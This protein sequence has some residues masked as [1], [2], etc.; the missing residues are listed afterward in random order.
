MNE[1][2]TEFPG[3]ANVFED[4]AEAEVIAP[5]PHR[6]QFLA[7]ST[8][9]IAAGVAGCRRPDLEILPFAEN[10]DRA[11]P[12]VPLY[13]ATAMPRS[14]GAAPLLVECND[15]RPTKIEGHPT[16][17]ASMGGTDAFAQAAILDLYSPDRSKQVLR[18]R[19]GQLVASSWTAFDAFAVEHFGALRKTGG[20]G[21]RFLSGKGLS[22]ATQLLREGVKARFPNSIWHEHEPIDDAS[23]QKGFRLAFGDLGPPMRAIPRFDAAKRILAL[24]S[25]FLGLE[26]P[27]AGFSRAFAN[28]RRD[29]ALQALV[30][31]QSLAEK[32]TAP[33]DAVNRLYVVESAYSST[34]TL[35]DHRLR[36][37]SSKIP[38]YLLALASL[39]AQRLG[40]GVDLRRGLNS[41]SPDGVPAAWIQEVAADLLASRGQCLILA[42]YRQPPIVHAVCAWLNQAL[43]NVGK[44]INYFFLPDDNARPLAELAIALNDGK[45]QTLVVLGGNPVFSAPA[46]LNF[47]QALSKAATVVSLGAFVDETSE[48]STWHLPEA[49]FLEMWDDAVSA[50]GRYC[51]VQP[52]IAPLHQGRSSLEALIHLSAHDNASTFVE[53]KSKVFPLLRASFEKRVESGDDLAFKAFIQRGHATQAKPPAPVALSEQPLVRALSE[54]RPFAIPPNRLEVTFC[55]SS[56]V[57]DGRYAWN[58]WLLELPDPLTKLV[59]DNAALIS[60]ATARRLEISTGDLLEIAVEAGQITIPAFIMPGQADDSIAL[61]LGHGKLRPAHVP[62]G[63]GFNVY[64]IRFSNQLHIAAATVKKTGGRYDLVTAQEH[65]TFPSEKRKGDVVRDLSWAEH[66]KKQLEASEHVH[67]DPRTRFQ[68]GYKESAYVDAGP[69]MEGVK[70]IALKTAQDISYPERLDGS[71]QWGMVVD[72]STCT[73]CSACMIACQAENNIP[74]VGKHEVKL[75]RSMHWI[76]IHRYFTRTQGPVSAGVEA[77]SAD[78]PP[79]VTQ[80][81][82]CQHCEAAPCESVCPVNA[83]VH[84]PEGLNLQVYNRCIGTRYCSNNC[85]YKARRFNWFDFNKRRL[86]QLRVPTPFSEAGVPETLKMQKNPEVT[87]RMRGVMEKCTYC[88][89]RIERAKIGAKVLAIKAGDDKADTRPTT[90]RR[91]EYRQGYAIREQDGKSQII[92]PDGVIKTACEQVCPTGAIVFGNVRD[93]SSRVFQIKNN[94][95][96]PDYLVIG[97][98]N[99]KP[100]TSYLPRLRNPNP[101]MDGHEGEEVG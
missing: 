81:M 39:L 69:G 48:R 60:P 35:A 27:G 46:E 5:S 6:R 55:P 19:N 65:G 17:P 1:S 56:S 53:A 57:F 3:Y 62:D 97:E 68:W 92:V 26:S 38:N 59:W 43:G 14:G 75:G 72:L 101:K 58:S 47:A 44:T 95:N 18:R 85:P 73:G 51:C 45:V 11:I 12:G 71:M 29:P 34:G 70:R 23:I 99:S 22:P 83:S 79:I 4:V 89:Q 24:D 42:G 9:A 82:M 54:H 25:D 100:R 15:G 78:D 32:A 94:E 76:N 84:S 98:I 93:A 10:P 21:L 30:A 13:Y 36:L 67:D 33:A 77:T 16:H 31:G 20:E 96:A 50:D 90:D 74:V 63:G 41:D 7:L 40:A 88:I 2:D 37:A 52:M 66:A 8:A 64:P 87:V 49:H 61:S 80:P 86:D 28:Q 91:G